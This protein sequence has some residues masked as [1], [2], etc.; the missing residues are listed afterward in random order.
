MRVPTKRV[1]AAQGFVYRKRNYFDK[2]NVAIW[3]LQLLV[4][5]VIALS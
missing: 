3:F 1:V 2:L 4:S 5:Y